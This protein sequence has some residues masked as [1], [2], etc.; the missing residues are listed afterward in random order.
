MENWFKEARYGMFIHWGAY[1]VA[2][3]GEW[4]LNRERIPLEE[5]KERYVRNFKAEHY[6]PEKWMKLAKDGGMKYVVLTAKHH[7]GFCL[8]DTKTT[9]F[10]SVKIGPGIDI[11]KGYVE[12]AR[13]ANLKVGIYYSPA[14]WNN[15]DYPSP[16]ARDWIE[17]WDDEEKRKHFVDYYKAQLTE[18][19]T[20]YG[21]IDLLWYD[22]CIP[23]PLDG[24]II[25]PYIKQLQPGIVINN[26]NGEP[27]DFICAEGNLRCP[28]KEKP[29]EAC[30]TMGDNWG[31]HRG[32]KRFKTP[33]EV[34]KMLI[35]V[36]V[37]D[38]NLLLNV[39]P[40]ADGSIPEECSNTIIKVG[41]WLEKNGE[42][43]YGSDK[44]PFSWGNSLQV[45]K[46][47][48]QVYVFH[49]KDVDEL[50]VAEFK[51]KVKS[52]KRLSDGAE[53]RFKQYSDGR[54]VIYDAVIKDMTETYKCE[55]DGKLEPITE[56]SMYWIVDEKE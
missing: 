7:D 45:A 19:M 28:T 21:K 41:K 35:D 9:D 25:N 24:K 13:K 44:A 31:Y 51:T 12:A 46:K 6:D 4:V 3:R 23:Q 40:R 42:A 29:W 22:G 47:G 52:I 39:G 38:G 1:A 56:K 50:C 27:C 5:Y 16:Y 53:M 18:L 10:N 17:T 54:F 55:L 26:R 49:Y 43:I 30:M 20:Q 36:S 32:D 33:E 14:D 15:P 37:A 2:A 8:W 48:K 11:V 34:I